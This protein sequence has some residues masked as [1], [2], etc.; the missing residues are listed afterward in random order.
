MKWDSNSIQLL[1]NEILE[2]IRKAPRA[3][4]EIKEHFGISDDQLNEAIEVLK[5]HKK[6]W[7]N[8][9]TMEYDFGIDK[10]PAPVIADKELD[11]GV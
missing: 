5:K 10:N 4:L 6:I 2:Y 7:R 9:K 1:W 8:T 3:S 11:L